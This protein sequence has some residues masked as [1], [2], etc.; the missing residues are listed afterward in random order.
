MAAVAGAG[1]VVPEVAP[2]RFAS[3][4]A[5]GIKAQLDAE[6]FCCV[7]ECLDAAEL[8]VARDLLW[9][10]LEGRE[11]DAMTQERPRGWARGDAATWTD[12]HGDGCGRRQPPAASRQPPGACGTHQR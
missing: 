7:A 1:F 6:G 12:G 8:E 2:A 4:D 9:Q 5:E 10:H 3:A 11:C